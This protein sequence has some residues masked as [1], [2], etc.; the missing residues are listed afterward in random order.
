MRIAGSFPRQGA[1]RAAPRHGLPRGAGHRRRR[2]R[3]ASSTG[4]VLAEAGW[5][6][7]MR[8]DLPAARTLLDASIEAQRAGAR[9]AAAAF[10][11]LRYQ[12]VWLGG[13]EDFSRAYD[14]T[15]EGLTMAETAGDV[16]GA[17][18]LRTSLAGQAT[19]L[20]RHEEGLA[21]AEHALADARRLRQPTLEAAA[22]YVYA[23]A[24]AKQEPQRAMT[25]LREALDLLRLLENNSERIP[26][27]GLL[28]ALEGNHG[29]ARRS[30]VAIRETILGRGI[31]LLLRLESRPGRPGLQ[32]RGLAGPGRECDGYA[33][34]R[35]AT[36][37][38]FYADFHDRP[39]EE[40]RPRR[41]RGVRAEFLGS[42]PQCRPRA[43]TT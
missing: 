30:L 4:G 20:D 34:Q 11:Y 18:G 42:A 1:A 19:M 3:H 37:P 40:A 15:W 5:A 31:A 21:D 28:A 39:I 9:F 43:S 17:I 12:A 16:M 41:R 14:E 10:V 27:L 33:T 32:P 8:G 22:L 6:K 23:L 25:L 7:A 2:R 24:L 36:P 35:A 13:T 26:A 38:P 29:S